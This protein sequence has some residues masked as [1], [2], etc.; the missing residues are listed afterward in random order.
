MAESVGQIGLDLVVNKNQFEKQMSGIQSLAKKTGAA[1]AAA[2][3]VKKLIDFGKQCV[4][5]GSDLAEVQNV[6]DVTFPRMSAQVDKF[7]K[8][9][10]ASFG[11][12]ET[13]AKKF[14]GTFGAM[15]KAFGFSEK[16]AYDMSTTLTGLAGDV[17]SFYNISQ[18]EAYTKLKSVFTGE[19]ES[20]KDLGVV[21]T[22]SALDAFAM[23]NGWGKT[24]QAMTEAE[25]V[26]L[27]YAFVQDQLATASGDFI[28]T[29]DGWAN[30][31]RVLKLNFE[32]LKATLGQGL[33]NV[34]TPVLKVINGI[35]EKL[36]TLASAFKSFTELITGNKSQRGSG[37]QNTVGELTDAAGAADSMADSTTAIGDAAESA[38]KKLGLMSFDKVQ[39]V[40]ST[41]DLSSGGGTAAI[42]GAGVD[43]GSLAEGETAIDKIDQKF[44][45]MFYN[46][47][48]QV[49]P[50]VDSLKRLWN[51]GLARLG[52][53]NSTALKDF[54]CNVLV[55]IG[56]WTFGVGIP[57]FIDA[58]NVGLMSVD[59]N[60]INGALN[61]LWDAITPFAINVGEGLL[62]FWENVLVPLGT[63]TANEI[64]PRFLE[65]LST[66]IEALNNILE[67]LKPLFQW[68]WES[69]LQPLANWAGGVFLNVW[70]K[71][72]GA[73]KKF[74]DWCAEHP[75]AI[76]NIAII[77]GSFFAAW[78]ISKFV[79]AAQGLI[80]TAT[81]I[82]GSIKS[83]AGAIS[84]V[85]YGL[86][87]LGGAFSP[88]VL[89][90]GAA[91][92]AGVLLWK[93][94][95]TIKEKAIA[96]WGAIKE[97]FD[98]VTNKISEFFSRLWSGIEQKFSDVGSW[99]SQK[100][101]AASDGIKSAFSSVGDFFKGVWAAIKR[102]FSSVS[103]WFRT[104]FSKAW[105]AVKKIF[106]SGGKVFDG[107]KDGILNGLKSV[108]NALINGINRVIEIPFNGI[109]GALDR[110]RSVS[111]LGK[112]PFNWIPTISVPQIPKLAQ[113]GF[114]KA[115]TPRL[116]MIGDNRHYGE[117]VAPEDKLQAMVNTAVKAASGSGISKTELQSLIDNATMR[118]ISALA[119]MGF[120]ID[121]EELAKAVLKA[122]DGLDGRYNPVKVY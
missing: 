16:E 9:A 6:V 3:G 106:S 55:P 20:L 113:G 45:K 79:S 57:R 22:Q 8:D 80:T 108:I 77:I 44:Q 30:Q 93:N 96:I 5:L 66:T 58:L 119:G 84:L 65:A 51:E 56:N 12:S 112:K 103:D 54:Y 41:K 98:S 24:T 47:K 89:G 23:A 94:W 11:L 97:W 88:V 36:M 100:F 86:S 19:T 26:A 18:N 73:L 72:N 43:L 4:E 46:I 95:D 74:S 15:A 61:N 14:T 78:K 82:V 64:V 62:W 60:K 68:F 81:N 104:E 32:S 17:A 122:I 39:K 42:G 1:L 114:V 69:V 38:A 52:E 87:L 120:Y 2:F 117:I 33:I 67:A 105:D 63:W 115:N 13:M 111:I 34:L 92:A 59:F 83:I 10:A 28:R 7:A 53:F 109:N 101:Q 110:I 91:I 90:V 102:P 107:I 31:V 70:D 85:K 27:R 116:A 50:T 118:I 37:I 71:I 99:F 121:G 29:S 48:N 21:M 25:K 49:Q 76:Q 40:Q 35:L 75:E